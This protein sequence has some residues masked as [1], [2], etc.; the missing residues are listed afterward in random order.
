MG[1]LEMVGWVNRGVLIISD[2][3]YMND[4]CLLLQ[5]DLAIGGKTGPGMPG[6]HHFPLPAILDKNKLELKQLIF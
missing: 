3:Y 2:E 6:V 4:R 1:H 5:T